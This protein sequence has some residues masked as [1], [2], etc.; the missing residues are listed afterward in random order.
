MGN[1][2]DTYLRE[3]YKKWGDRDYLFELHGDKYVPTTY[4]D[5]IERVNYFAAYL[6]DQGF[7]GKNIGI[8]GPNSIR[9]LIA[10]VAI[11]GYVGCSVGFSKDWSYENASY[12]VNKADLACLIYDEAMSAVTDR[13]K[14]EHPDIR[15]ISMQNDFDECV[16]EGRKLCGSLFDVQPSDEDTP[17]KI[18]FTSGTTSFPKAVMLSVRNIFSGWRT[19]GRRVQLGENDRCYLFLP[20]NHTY[21]SIYNYMYSL[22]FGY[23]VYLANNVHDMPREMAIAQ[24]TVFSGVPKIFT[25][26]HEASLASGISLSALF[27][28]KMKYL[29]SGGA[30]LSQEMRKAYL[31]EGMY[32]MNAYGLSETSSGFCIDYPEEVDLN[33]AGT[34]M[35]DIEAVVL[36][37]DDEGY[38]ELAVKGDLIFKGYY[39]DEEATARM[40]NKDGYFLTG[41]IG[42]I[43]NKKVYL[44][45]RKDTLIS[46]PNGENVSAKKIEERVR[47]LSS[48]ISSVKV[49]VRDDKLCTDIFL[50]EGSD[51]ADSTN[52]DELIDR[53]NSEVSGY[54]RIGKYHIYSSSKLLK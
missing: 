30:M 21:G 43:R 15:F 22:V 37:P 39:G 36:D 44:K 45:C 9:W 5:F 49:Y 10:D 50:K 2:L 52:W 40:F 32:M 47:T 26:F 20:L 8:Y 16:E 48:D 7:G 6:K 17:A 19:L 34:L 27:G 3:D 28:G 13:L 33:S 18:V 46:L 42:I 25:R 29:F 53:L 38:G 51:K 54:E 35:E 14:E 1:T 12:S 4:A 41:D 31:K 11:I 24:P 23:S